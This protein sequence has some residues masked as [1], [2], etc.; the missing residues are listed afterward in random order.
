M[1]MGSWPVIDMTYDDINIK[2][3]TVSRCHGVT[4]SI[5]SIYRIF[6]LLTTLF[7]DSFIHKFIFIIYVIY[8]HIRPTCQFRTF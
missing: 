5:S 3:M 6:C 7:H 1:V 2:I 8:C 4:L